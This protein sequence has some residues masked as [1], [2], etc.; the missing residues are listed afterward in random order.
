LTFCNQTL[1]E[2]AGIND[3]P[4]Y[5]MIRFLADRSNTSV[6]AAV[7]NSNSKTLE[8]GGPCVC[9]YISDFQLFL[10]ADA[11]LTNLDLSKR[12]PLQYAASYGFENS[13]RLLI[14]KQPSLVNYVTGTNR[15]W[16]PLHSAVYKGQCKIAQMLLEND[17][18]VNAL[19]VVYCKF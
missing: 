1:P 2:L 11:T 3:P 4:N 10:D 12:T 9:D 8:V 19:A 13:A 14:E 17:A 7:A 5:E 6:H 16:S 18:D 15:Q